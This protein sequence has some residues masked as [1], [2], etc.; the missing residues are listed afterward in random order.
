MSKA[1]QNITNAKLDDVIT[2]SNQ[3]FFDLT[4][5]R[6]SGVIILNPPYGERMAIDEITSF[7]KEIGNKLKKDFSGFTAWIIS[8]NIDATHAVGLRATRRIA[9]FN[10]SLECKFL[11]Y[12][13]YSG[14]KKQPPPTDS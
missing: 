3:S 8:S 1:K 11:K 10:G 2:L 7:Y 14:S 4:T 12:E 6:K 9:L 5:E 13:L